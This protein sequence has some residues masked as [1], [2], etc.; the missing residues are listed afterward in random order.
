MSEHFRT[1]EDALAYVQVHDDH[2]KRLSR[3]SLPTLR[4]AASN[5]RQAARITLLEGGAVSRDELVAEILALRYPLISEARQEV[6]ARQA[7]LAE[8]VHA[9]LDAQGQS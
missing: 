4:G 9:E 2:A 3:A 1:P 6:S 8:Q 7:L 5:A